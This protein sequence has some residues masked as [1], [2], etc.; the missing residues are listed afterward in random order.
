MLPR[1]VPLEPRAKWGDVLRGSA[2]VVGSRTTVGRQY[3]DLK[4]GVVSPYET[5]AAL[6]LLYGDPAVE[7]ARYERTRSISGDAQLLARWLLGRVASRVRGRQPP[8]EE[9]RPFVVSTHVAAI[10]TDQAIKRV[11]GWLRDGE[12]RQVFFVH[13]H[14]LNI[15]S[16]DDTL[17]ANLASG[18]LV[19]ADGVGVRLAA[20]ILGLR[21]PANLNGTD[22]VPEL[23]LELS[24]ERVPVALVGGAP[25]V[26]E[27]AAAHWAART[28]V[29]VV[30]A[31]N[32]FA[33]SEEYRAM[34]DA[35]AQAAPCLVLVGMGSPRQE[36]F[37][38]H[39]FQGVA[40]VVAMT[41]GGLFDFVGGGK[42]R[43]PLPV[44]EMGL[45]WA[46][47]LALE[48]RRLG[49]RYILGNPEFV[50]RAIKQRLD[51]R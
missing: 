22:L 41:V 38:R 36:Q 50:L 3:L 46:W 35:V 8:R 20:A 45:E 24:A 28:G 23:L 29:R 4:R 2:R 7:E 18:D 6:G 43:A 12:S 10:D 5:R 30:G 49:R 44:R 26:A 14:A 9:A 47:R 34:T 51:A 16:R 27:R 13:P 39:H 21:L 32:G 25:G 15:A 19:L 1:E 40:G 31:W 42:A 11:V 33:T 17:R 48:P 37:A